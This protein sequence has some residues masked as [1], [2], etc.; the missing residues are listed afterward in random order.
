MNRQRAVTI[1]TE[2]HA[3][4]T[5][6]TDAAYIAHPLQVKRVQDSDDAR[7][8]AGLHDVVEDCPSWTFERIED[9]G[10]SP[11][12]IEALRRVRKVEDESYQDFNVRTAGNPISRAVKIADL[13]NTGRMRSRRRTG[14]GS[15]SAHEH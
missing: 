7:I 14:S 9:E 4:Q 2:A 15:R 12:V 3:G 10:F 8:V 11:Q 6:K 1:A 13:R 5:D